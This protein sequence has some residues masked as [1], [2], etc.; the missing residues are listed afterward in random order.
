VSTIAIRIRSLQS[1][2]VRDLWLR[3]LTR[4]G[5]GVQGIGA[6][7]PMVPTPM[8][9][10]AM[11]QHNTLPDL[12]GGNPTEMEFYHVPK[13]TQGSVPFADANGVL[14]EDNPNLF[15]D[16]AANRLGIRTDAPG[17]PLHVAGDIAAGVD[18]VTAGTFY[19]FSVTAGQFATLSWNMLTFRRPSNNYIQVIPAAGLAGNVEFRLKDVWDVVQRA[20]LLTSTPQALFAD[21][22]VGAPA[23]SF[24]T[25]TTMGMYRI[26]LNQLGLAAGGVLALTLTN[27]PQAL[28]RDGTAA[29]PGLAFGSETA[30]GIGRAGA[31]TGGL[32]VGGAYAAYWTATAFR[33]V[34]DNVLTL[35]IVDVGFQAL[36]LT[37]AAHSPAAEGEARIN[38]GSNAFEHRIGTVVHRNGLCIYSGSPVTDT[39]VSAVDRTLDSFTI[40]AAYW[41]V[42]KRITIVAPILL[43]RETPANWVQAKLY[44]GTT[45][46]LYKRITVPGAPGWISAHVDLEMSFVVGAIAGAGI[47]LYPTRNIR[48]YNCQSHAVYDDI[49]NPVTPILEMI[50]MEPDTPGIAIATNAAKA[51]VVKYACNDATSVVHVYLQGLTIYAT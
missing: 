44:I 19:A 12:Q 20:L 34:L 4:Q 31:G 16:D 9:G 2:S 18:G 36:H 24:I 41:K 26:A 13:L 32:A 11:I 3:D 17:Y 28:L 14:A 7:G 23:A 1:P 27:T 46:V 25:E 43:E 38:T 50:P 10:S 47:T 21:G 15:W 5:Y 51:I 48:S 6:F 37:N 49:N 29:L 22:V 39:V 42:G 33:P 40:P 8:S 35:G 45:Q 30:L